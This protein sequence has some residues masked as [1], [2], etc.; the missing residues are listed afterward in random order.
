MYMTPATIRKR[1]FSVLETAEKNIHLYVNTPGSDMTRHRLCPFSDTVKATLCLTMNRT[2]TELFNFFM[3][4]NKNVPSKSA[5]T[6]Q[7]KKLTADFFPYLLKS[8][9]EKI[10]FIKTYKG[11]HLVAVDGSDINLPTNKNDFEYRIKQARSDNV[12]F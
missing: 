5:F 4:Q 8:F 12:F 2:N 11:V 3:S 6:Q 9:N 7:R 1:F 10:P